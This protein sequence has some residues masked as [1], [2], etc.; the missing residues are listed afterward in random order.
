MAIRRGPVQCRCVDVVMAKNQIGMV[1][2]QGLDLGQVA[3]CRCGSKLAACR[4]IPVDED[5]KPI[6]A[7]KR[8]ETMARQQTLCWQSRAKIERIFRILE[9]PTIISM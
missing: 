8:S 2:Q 9:F 5:A 1:F 4:V 7:K 6:K 3:V